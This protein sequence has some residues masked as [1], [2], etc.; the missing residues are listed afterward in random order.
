MRVFRTDRCRRN[1]NVTPSPFADGLDLKLELVGWKGKNSLRAYV[2]KNER[3]H[4]LRLLGADTS[5]Y[6]VNKFQLKREN[7][8]KEE[9]PEQVVREDETQEKPMPQTVQ[10]IDMKDEPSRPTDC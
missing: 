6:E 5:M 8:K 9:T 1:V 7:E 3:V 2:E 10:D 4:F